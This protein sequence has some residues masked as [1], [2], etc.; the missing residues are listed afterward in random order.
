MKYFSKIYLIGFLFILLVF[1]CSRHSITSRDHDKIKTIESW[2]LSLMD[3][4]A[5]FERALDSEEAGKAKSRKSVLLKCD[6]QLLDTIAYHLTTKHK[7]N[8]VKKPNS[9]SGYIR[10]DAVCR[11]EE[12]LSLDINIYDP[13]QN[14]LVEVEVKN[15]KDMFVKNDKEF[16]EYCA[17]V[18]AKIVLNQ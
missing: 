18:I 17:A 15:G 10:A 6:V 9:T 16:A 4:M 14:L 1:S 5:V 7:V 2:Y 3:E 11:W 12:Y 8:L 13:E